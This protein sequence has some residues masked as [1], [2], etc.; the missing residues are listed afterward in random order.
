MHE[1][2]LQAEVPLRRVLCLGAHCDDIEIGCGATVLALLA[3]TPGMTV[4][5]VV[6]SGTA[7]R[8]AEGRAAAAAFLGGAASSRVVIHDFRDGFFPG[9]W[10]RIKECFNALAAGDAPDLILTHHLQDLHQ[11]H[12]TIGELTWQTFRNRLIWEYEIPKYDGDLGR[13]NLFMPVSEAHAARKVEI[14]LRSFPSQAGKSWFSADTFRALL[15]LRGI[16]AGSASGRAEAFHAPK[17]VV[18][19]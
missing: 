18:R 10:T 14:I 17:T 8:A 13:P 19:A 15:R 12:R 9:E 11:D 16:E 1:L 3:G 6:F 7:D 2:N 5:W 4:D